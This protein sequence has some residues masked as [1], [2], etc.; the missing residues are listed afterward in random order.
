MVKILICQACGKSFEYSGSNG[1]K[2]TCSHECRYALL[3]TINKAKNEYV[4]IKC[5]RC[6]NTFTTTPYRVSKNKKFCSFKCKYPEQTLK[7]CK[8]CNKEFYVRDSEIDKQYCSKVCADTGV[9]RNLKLSNSMKITWQDENKK[10]NLIQGIKRRSS[11]EEWRQ[12]AHFQK[13]ELHPRYKGNK[14]LREGASRYE[15]KKWVKDVFKKDDYTCQMCG[16][17]KYLRAHHIKEWAKYPEFRYEISNGMTL[18]ED[19]HLE[20]HGKKQKQVTKTCEFCGKCFRP[21][22]RMQKFCSL[23]CFYMCPRKK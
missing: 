21:S 13:G 6:G 19:C 9:E 2:K 10:A 18:C 22:K 4:E 16:S 14:R 11:S 23:N 20:I 17:K 5:E 12:S 1:S 15:Y 7:T 8:S 3:S